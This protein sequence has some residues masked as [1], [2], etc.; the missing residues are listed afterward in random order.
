MQNMTVSES[1][2]AAEVANEWEGLDYNC[3]KKI[4]K[5]WDFMKQYVKS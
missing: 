4:R 2:R 1:R 5:T 3:E